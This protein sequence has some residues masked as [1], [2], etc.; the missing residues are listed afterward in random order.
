MALHYRSPATTHPNFLSEVLLR[1]FW[2]LLAWLV[3]ERLPAAH[4]DFAFPV[5]AYAGSYGAI[6]PA[7]LQFDRQYSAFWIQATH[8]RSPVRRDEAALRSFL[9]NAQTHVVVPRRETDVTCARL[10][11]HLQ[12]T[13]PQWPGLAACATALHMSAASLQR[14]LAV[15]GSSFQS[16]KDELRRD[17]AITRLSTSK[18]QLAALADELGFA[19]SASFQR[20]FKKWTGSTPGLYRRGPA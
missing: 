9:V 2:R 15:E 7:P 12:S 16:L 3:D 4:F 14:H 1:I 20:A 5:P 10:R 18:V 6:F 8:L 13:Q 11:N 17:L 19:D